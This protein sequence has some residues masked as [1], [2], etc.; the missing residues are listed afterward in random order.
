MHYI[1]IWQNLI[2]NPDTQNHH[3]AGT[4]TI[5]KLSLAYKRLPV[6]RPIDPQE[7]ICYYLDYE[8][9]FGKRFSRNHWT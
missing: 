1:I 4:R 7:H 5:M 9:V 8:Y 2:K 3:S 6:L